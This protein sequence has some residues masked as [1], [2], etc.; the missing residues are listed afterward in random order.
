MA[1]YLRRWYDGNARPNSFHLS[2]N[3]PIRTEEA[4]LASE[5]YNPGAI[6]NSL[7]S[8]DCVI[9]GWPVASWTIIL[10]R[11]GSTVVISY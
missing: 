6:I 1:G 9:K 2:G 4:N 7:V 8:P 10:D 3:W 11:E 5:E